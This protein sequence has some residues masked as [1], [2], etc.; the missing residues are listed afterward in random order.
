MTKSLPE[1]LSNKDILLSLNYCY[2]PVY[3][4]RSWI[5]KTKYFILCILKYRFHKSIFK[6]H[7][8]FLNKLPFSL[9]QTEE[10]LSGL[11]KGF[12]CVLLLKLLT[13]LHF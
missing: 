2:S 6:K 5:V 12:R 13:D 10:I 3:A 8:F 1:A 4:A 7:F 9:V 11:S